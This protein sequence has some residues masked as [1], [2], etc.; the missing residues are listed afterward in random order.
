MIWWTLGFAALVYWIGAKIGQAMEELGFLTGKPGTRVRGRG[1][2][3]A[4]PHVRRQQA[5]VPNAK[6]HGR[7]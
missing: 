4:G 1:Y 5:H 2:G 3:G 6:G 7:D